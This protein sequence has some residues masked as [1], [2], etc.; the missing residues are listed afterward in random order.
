MTAKSSEILA[1]ALDNVGLAEMAKSARQDHYHD[2][3]SE[4]AMC[5][6]T[7]EAELRWNR[8][9]ALDPIQARLIEAIRQRH[10][11]GE[12]DAS[13]E[14]S[15]DWAKSPEGQEAFRELAKGK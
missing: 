6:L 14:E 12:F 8:D 9:H 15:D 5:S 11:N 4:D 13:K 2:F 10:L 1:Q 3:L 7:L